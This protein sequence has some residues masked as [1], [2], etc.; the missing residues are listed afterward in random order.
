EHGHVE[1]RALRREI[2]CVPERRSRLVDVRDTAVTG[3]PPVRGG[4]VAEPR[5]QGRVELAVVAFGVPGGNEPFVTEVDGH[6]LPFDVLPGE[7]GRGG[8]TH[9]TAG[10]GEGGRAV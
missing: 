4:S 9:G 1:Y 8:H 10:Q 2:E 3:G 5:Q 6:A 7:C